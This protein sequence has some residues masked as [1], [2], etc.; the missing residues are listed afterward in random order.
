V[1]CAFRSGLGTLVGLA[2][3]PPLLRTRPIH[4]AHFVSLAALGLATLFPS[5]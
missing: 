2:L 4:I 3:N 5:L 1:P